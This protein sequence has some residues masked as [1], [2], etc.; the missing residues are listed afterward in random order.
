MLAVILRR[1]SGADRSGGL[2]DAAWAALRRPQGVFYRIITAAETHAPL[3]LRV[4]PARPRPD[5]GNHRSRSSPRP[6]IIEHRN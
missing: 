3:D 6:A 4:S 5:L 2:V 1:R